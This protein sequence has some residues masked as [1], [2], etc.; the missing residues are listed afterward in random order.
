VDLKNIWH[1][2][3]DSSRVE[4]L[5]GLENAAKQKLAARH[6]AAASPQCCHRHRID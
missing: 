2:L 4:S 3:S 5:S 6:I 1:H